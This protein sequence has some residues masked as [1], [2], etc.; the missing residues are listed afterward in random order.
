MTMKDVLFSPLPINEF[1]LLVENS[2]RRVLSENIKP[3][4]PTD[5]II[6]RDELCKRLDITEPT[7]IRMETKG[8]LPTLRVGSNVRYNWPDVIKALYVK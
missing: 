4:Q 7:A 3:P 8:K 6:S 2:I 1:E 5:E